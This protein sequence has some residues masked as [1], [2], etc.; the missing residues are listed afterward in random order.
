MGHFSFVVISG[1]HTWKE[2]KF[3][4]QELEN[5]IGTS[6][7]VPDAEFPIAKAQGTFI[8]AMYN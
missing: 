6:H 2:K 7:A 8:S 5:T 3:F 1:K 4:L